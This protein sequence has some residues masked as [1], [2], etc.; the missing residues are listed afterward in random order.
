MTQS[1]CLP[2]A[3]LQRTEDVSSE[4]MGGD[5]SVSF[6]VSVCV[7]GLMVTYD[8]NIALSTRYLDT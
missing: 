3:V 1:T 4:V 2:S 6:T 5:G 8:R 7:R